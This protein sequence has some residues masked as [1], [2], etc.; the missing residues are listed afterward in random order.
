MDSREEDDTVIAAVSSGEVVNTYRCKVPKKT[1]RD[2]TFDHI[3][4]L[5]CAGIVQGIT[6]I[7]DEAVL[8]CV[9]FNGESGKTRMALI[10]DEDYCRGNDVIVESCANIECRNTSDWVIS[11]PIDHLVTV[12]LVW[13]G[14][15]VGGSDDTAEAKKRI[16]RENGIHVVDSPAE[17][18]KK[19][20][21]VMG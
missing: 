10:Q 14:S 4:C 18:G 6:Y 12:D 16:M 1:G 3:K 15:I 21:E 11:Q 20:K 2:M 19:V 17:I 9:Y 13:H 7:Q 5:T 8:A